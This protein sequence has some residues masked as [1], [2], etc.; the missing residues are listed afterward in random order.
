MRWVLRGVGLLSTMILVRILSPDDFGVVAMGMLVVA[1]LQVISDLGVARLLI[2]IKDPEPAHYN[3]AWTIII[4]QSFVVSLLLIL[5]APIAAKYFNE[6]RVVDVIRWL[7]LGGIFGAFANIGVIQFRK[8]LRFNQDFWYEVVSKII[9][10]TAT[11]IL[12]F[13]ITSYWALIYGTIVASVSKVYLSYRFHNYRPKISLEKWREFVGFSLWV[14]PASIANF[15]L[16]RA[17][18]LIVGI[19]NST[20]QLGIYNTTSEI[21][22]MMTSEI[23]VPMGRALYPNYAKLLDTPKLLAEVYCFTV[24]T[25]VI[26]SLAIGPGLAA[27]AE[28]FVYVLLGDQWVFAIPLMRW[29]AL[30][31]AFGSIVFVL[32]DQIFVVTGKEKL[33]LQLYGV[34]VLFMIPVLVYVGLNYGMIEIAAT[35]AVT[36]GLSILL[37]A[38]NVGRAIPLSL[39]RVLALLFRPPLAAVVLFF[40]LNYLPYNDISSHILRLLTDVVVGA[41]AYISTLIVSWILAARPEGP[42]ASI[43]RLIYGKIKCSE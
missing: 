19:V 18:A 25:V 8:E 22:K 29:L 10:V 20:S 24:K 9:A 35:T 28:D 4:L 7:A 1:L 33:A 26:I 13:L 16:S 36:T 41:I 27:V 23:I 21:S 38:Y 15:A 37:A 12:A 39:L 6:P 14:T 40:P 30:T 43:I 3:S 5:S 32:R 17:D 31:G 2:R 34:Q 42:E 11:L